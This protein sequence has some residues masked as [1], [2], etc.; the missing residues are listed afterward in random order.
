MQISLKLIQAIN[1][2]KS[3]VC[4]KFQLLVTFSSLFT[5][6]SVLQAFPRLLLYEYD[7]KVISF[8]EYDLSKYNIFA[9]AGPTD[10]H[11]KPHIEMRG[12]I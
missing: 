5:A 7:F 1:H 4:T 3:T 2:A 9:N 8:F 10:G 11:T 6:S 12:R